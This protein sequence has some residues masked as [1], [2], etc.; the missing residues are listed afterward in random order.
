MML[1]EGFNDAGAM[2]H[3]ISTPSLRKKENDNEEEP[4]NSSLVDG[5]SWLVGDDRQE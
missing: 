1:I 2:A 5:S 3:S 4:L